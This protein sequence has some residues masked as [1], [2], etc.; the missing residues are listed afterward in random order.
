MALDSEPMEIGDVVSLLS[1]GLVKVAVNEEERRWRI[2]GVRSIDRTEWRPGFKI[3]WVD[4]NG[5]FP[6]WQGGVND[7][8]ET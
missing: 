2:G 1:N 3:V 7:K 8:K 5:S 4:E 6:I